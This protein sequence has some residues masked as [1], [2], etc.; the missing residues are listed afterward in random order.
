MKYTAAICNSIASSV[1]V[2]FW[3][4]VRKLMSFRFEHESVVTITNTL[5]TKSKQPLATHRLEIE[6]E[7]W[8]AQ[9]REQFRKIRNYRKRQKRR[10]TAK[11]RL[12]NFKFVPV[13]TS[14]FQ[15]QKWRI[16]LSMFFNKYSKVR[17]RHPNSKLYISI[18]RSDDDLFDLIVHQGKST[19]NPTR[20]PGADRLSTTLI[21]A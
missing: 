15:R 6:I 19:Q 20:P 2:E 16:S 10:Q 18:V 4:L 5:F 1:T 11:M 7:G 17:T 13:S 12:A 14:C 3:H 21:R 8:P 9:Q